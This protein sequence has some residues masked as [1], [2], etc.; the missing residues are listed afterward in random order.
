M[1]HLNFFWVKYRKEVWCHR[2]LRVNDSRCRQKVPMHDAEQ[3]DHRAQNSQIYFVLPEKGGL[4]QW[5]VWQQNLS[6]WLRHSRGPGRGRRKQMEWCRVRNA[7]ASG[8]GRGHHL[9][10]S[11]CHTTNFVTFGKLLT[12]LEQFPPLREEDS[13]LDHPWRFPSPVPFCIWGL[14]DI[15]FTWETRRIRTDAQ[16]V[17]GGRYVN[18]GL[19]RK[20]EIALVWIQVCICV[21][22][23]VTFTGGTERCLRLGLSPGQLTRTTPPREPCFPLR[24]LC[25]S[26][27]P[28]CRRL[29][30]WGCAGLLASSPLTFS[31]RL[32]LSLQDASG[33]AHGPR[34][35]T[36][37]M[38]KPRWNS[39]SANCPASRIRHDCVCFL[40][41]LTTC[42][43][44]FVVN[45]VGWMWRAGNP[46]QVAVLLFS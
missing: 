33:G 34:E 10:F 3:S 8:R 37:L 15:R 26:P 22:G 36:F 9:G 44:T 40:P 39:L 28:P 42:G 41:A 25:S 27:F 32:H 14:S 7:L 12:F 17:E 20:G 23:Q 5:P 24:G 38:P 43:C 18:G 13:S 46:C 4:F 35:I 2:P 45:R 29:C 6:R 11:F 1:S 31:P 21:H 16:Q 19:A 30:T